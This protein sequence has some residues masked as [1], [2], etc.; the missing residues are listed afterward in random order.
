MDYG[1]RS[2]QGQIWSCDSLDTAQETVT[3]APHMQ[4]VTREPGGSWTALPSAT[5][6]PVPD[7]SSHDYSPHDT[8]VHADPR[9]ADLDTAARYLGEHSSDNGQTWQPVRMPPGWATV[10]GGHVQA[11]AASAL[12]GGWDVIADGPTRII[13]EG[14]GSLTRWTIT[15]PNAH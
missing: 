12:L 1:I 10:C 6:R 13:R 14:D 8:A 3:E 7:S 11:E 9:V 5:R 15:D 4:I 2:P